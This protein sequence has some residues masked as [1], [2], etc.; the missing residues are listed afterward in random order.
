MLDRN[1]VPHINSYLGE[2]SA[3]AE[4]SYGEG[5]LTWF[6]S[7]CNLGTRFEDVYDSQQ[8]LKQHLGKA[9]SPDTLLYICKELA[10]P[11]EYFPKNERKDLTA[12]ILAG[13][14]FEFNE[15][16]SIGW[17][18]EL[19]VDTALKLGRL[20]KN[21]PYILDYDTTDLQ[22]KIAGSRKWYGGNGKK[23]YCPA[24]AMINK[25][26]IYIENRNGDS[27]PSFNLVSNIEKVVNLL[28]SKGIVIDHIRIDAVGYDK[29]FTE[30]VNSRRLKYITRA[31]RPVVHKQ[32]DFIKNWHQTTIKKSTA[33]VGD[34]VYRFGKDETRIVIKAQEKEKTNYW[35]LITNDFELSNSEIIKLYDLRGDS[36]NMFRDL[37]AF[38][39][40]KLP[41]RSFSA[42]TV[43]LYITALNYILFRFI[44][45]LFAPKMPFIN[46]NMRLETFIKKFKR[47]NDDMLRSLKKASGYSALSGFT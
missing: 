8:T 43:Y 28:Q 22:N 10:L 17:F 16:N 37:K 15:V 18:N 2:R 38:G 32:K 23:A 5:I 11:N 40:G 9:M 13:K 27:S 34:T 47:V 46:E 12:K 20:R 39:L 1:I 31:D 24:L 45:K 41:M 25:I 7:Q 19:L 6:I 35:G 42:N 33:L 29:G 14:A 36:E 30:F 4:Y 26:P 44:T 3:R 21:E